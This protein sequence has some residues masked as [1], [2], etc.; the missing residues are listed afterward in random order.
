MSFTFTEEAESA[1]LSNVLS[2][3]PENW[4]YFAVDNTTDDVEKIATGFWDF[5]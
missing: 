5:T 4:K 1:V 2:H 3:V